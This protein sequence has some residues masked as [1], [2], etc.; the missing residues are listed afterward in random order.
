MTTVTKLHF[1]TTDPSAAYPTD[2]SIEQWGNTLPESDRINF[3]QAYRDQA[4]IANVYV[5]SGNLTISYEHDDTLYT[6]S[7]DADA[8]TFAL[9]PDM[10]TWVNK[11]AST[12]GLTATVSNTKVS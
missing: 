5:Q 12:F 4:N 8:E 7:N 3:R 2:L 9:T 10:Q 6:W 1:T 11:Y